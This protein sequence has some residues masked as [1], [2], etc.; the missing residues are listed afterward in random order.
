MV[1]PAL[2][3]QIDHFCSGVDAND[4]MTAIRQKGGERRTQFPE[5]DDTNAHK[6]RC[7]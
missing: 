5:A 3:Q 6:Y 4:V 2:V 1:V 7:L